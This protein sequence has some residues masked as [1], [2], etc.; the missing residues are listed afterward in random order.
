MKS[1]QARFIG[2]I[3]IPVTGK[4]KVDIE[5]E[6]RKGLSTMKSELTFG[7]L[8][9]EFQLNPRTIRYYEDVGLLPEPRRSESG[10]RLYSRY[11]L[12]R[13]RLIHRAAR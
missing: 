13:L 1:I 10:Y 8:G 2:E 7:E 12:E 11:E 6:K 5:H 9:G 4:Y 3:D